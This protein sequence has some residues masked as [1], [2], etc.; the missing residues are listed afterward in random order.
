MS[1]QLQLRRGTSAEHN[2]FTGALGEVT[3][4][5]TTKELH[6][7]DGI[8][9]GGMPIPTKEK[10]KLSLVDD[11]LVAGSYSLTL[12]DQFYAGNLGAGSV[13]LGTYA[14]DSRNKITGSPA[15]LRGVIGGYDNE[16]NSASTADGLACGIVWSMHSKISNNS[17]HS[18]IGFGSYHEIE[19]GSYAAIL[20]GTRNKIVGTTN[21]NRNQNSVIVGGARTEVDGANSV[22]GGTDNKTRGDGLVAFGLLNN[23]GLTTA[24]NYSFTCGQSNT[25]EREYSFTSGLSNTSSRNYGFTAG[26]QNQNN[27]DYAVVKGRGGVVGVAFAESFGYDTGSAIGSNQRDRYP[28]QRTTENATPQN[29]VSVLQGS[30]GDV[31]PDNTVCVATAKVVATSGTDV[32]VFELKVCLRRAGGTS[33]VYNT[34]T[35][36]GATA[37]ASAWTCAFGGQNDRRII[38]TGEAGKTIKWTADVDMFLTKL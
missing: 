12:G 24:A 13:L 31:M 19:R 1:S 2:V 7:H 25:V 33:A 15:Q 29:L 23:I 17:D 26:R 10:L 18:G 28:L 8:A 11:P 35:V 32:A 34:T 14:G 38:A 36:I 20:S 4:N 22:A 3:V 5:T 16:I 21:P 37:G 9:L 30:V 27:A 6:L